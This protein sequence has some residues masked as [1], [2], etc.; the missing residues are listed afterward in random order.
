MDCVY[1]TYLNKRAFK[2]T[3][4]MGTD[5]DLSIRFR[6][7]PPQFPPPIWDFYQS[8]LQDSSKTNNVCER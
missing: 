2:T 6:R 1:R 4:R 5:D 8:T 7:L 3:S